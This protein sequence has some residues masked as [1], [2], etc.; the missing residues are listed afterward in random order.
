MGAHDWTGLEE[1]ET[2]MGVVGVAQ[3]VQYLVFEL[4]SGAFA[5]EV[6]KVR[7]ILDY[8]TI[9]KV[10]GAPEFVRGVIKVRGR[11]VPVADL[12]RKFGLTATEESIDTCILVLEVACAGKTIMLGVL[13]DSVEE[14]IEF[15]SEQIETGSHGGTGI[16]AGF[17]KGIAQRDE[18]VLMLLDID[19]V[20]TSDELA[21]VRG[22]NGGV[23]GGSYAP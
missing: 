1:Q 20:F 4:G 9:T 7:E 22:D 17:I 13:A 12:G 18:Q 11:V 5:V 3:G 15:T 19:R 8:T 16:H 6:A 23:A 21:T 10:P 2:A 14:V